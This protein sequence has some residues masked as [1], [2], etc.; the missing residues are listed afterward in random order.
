MKGIQMSYGTKH[1]IGLVFTVQYRIYLDTWGIDRS[2]NN[3]AIIIVI[4]LERN[5]ITE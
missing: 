3:K 1:G 5:G 2:R 4:I